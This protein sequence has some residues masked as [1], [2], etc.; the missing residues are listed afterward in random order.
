MTCPLAPENSFLS[1]L[2]NGIVTTDQHISAFFT[3]SGVLAV[4]HEDVYVRLFVETLTEAAIEWFGQ[5]PVGSMTSWATLIQAF[6]RRFKTAEDEHFLLSQLTQMKKEIH[7]PMREFISHFNQMVNRIPVNKRPTGE[8]QMT[9]FI[10]AQPSDV[11]F[12]LRRA[13]PPDLAAAQTL[14]IEVEDDFLSSG[15]WSH[16]LQKGKGQKTHVTTTNPLYQK[17]ANDVLQLKK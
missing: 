6:E 11:S 14:A 5:L 7:G 9:F 17:L 4:Q 10:N 1:F 3:A 2:Y 12:Q 15:K 13:R 16:D 8:N